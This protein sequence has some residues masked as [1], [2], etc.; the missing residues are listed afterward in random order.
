[1]H[2]TFVNSIPRT[3]GVCR[4]LFVA[5]AFLPR[6]CFAAE[7]EKPATDVSA[8]RAAID[9]YVA[10]Y[11]RGD[12]K[13]VAALWS[14]SGEWLSPSG[15]KFQGRKAIE[16]EM[17]SLFDEEKGV[18]I[19]V[20]N[21]TIRIVSPDTAIEEGTVRVTHPSEPPSESTYLAVDVKEE[22][23]WKLN[24]VRETDI[25]EEPAASSDLDELSWL[26]GDWV[27]DSPDV[28]DTAS[29]TWT[30]N[31]TFLTY[32]FKLSSPESDEELEGTQIIG[33]D[34]AAG[35]I[36]SWMFDSDGGFGEGTWSKHG[37]TWVVKFSQVL[38]DGRKASATNVYTMI[39]GN[40]FTWKSIGRKVGNEFLPNIDEVK[41]VRKS[42]VEAAKGKGNAVKAPKS[43]RKK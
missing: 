36:R 10:A 9:S 39:D 38:P 17:Q 40:T 31:K 41:M 14:E 5:A 12:A 11:N 34:P 33:W 25:P 13:A 21:P 2:R 15:Q 16:R 43:A 3:A 20:I 28:D 18:H 37:D 19:E 24:T 22:G 32:S 7:A 1:M 30:K 6:V 23:R 4:S 42:A 8:I 26:A 29:V 35:T 27:D